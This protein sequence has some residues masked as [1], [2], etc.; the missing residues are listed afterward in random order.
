MITRKEVGS[1][2]KYFILASAFLLIVIFSAVKTTAVDP[3]WSVSSPVN[4][5]SGQEDQTQVYSYNLTANIS[6]PDPSMI[7][8]F[9]NSPS[10]DKPIISDVHGINKDV[11]FFHWI[12]LNGTTGILK[13][14]ATRDNETA[15]YNIS[16]NLDF[17][18]ES[19]GSRMFVFNITAINDRPY[20][21]S[22]ANQSFNR[23]SLFEYIVNVSDEESNTPYSMNITFLNCSVAAWSTRNCSGSYP[24]LTLFNSSQYSFS[25]NQ[26][27]ISFTPS[28]NDVG[29]YTINFTVIDSGNTTLPH[30]ASTSQIVLFEV[31]N[32][33]EIPYF[34]F[35]CNTSQSASAREDLQFPCYINATDID[36]LN[37]LT[38]SANYTWFNFSESNASSV[39]I[40]GQYNFSTLVKIN[41]TDLQVGNWSINITITDRGVPTASNSTILNL[42][43]A[44]INDSVSLQSIPDITAYTSQTYAVLVNA[45]DNDLLIP[46]K[47]VLNEALTFTTNNT[48]VTV[49]NQLYFSGT[50][51]SQVTLSFDPNNFTSGLNSI[52]VTVRDKDNNSISSDIFTINISDNSAPLWNA[53]ME[54]NFTLIEGTE[55]Y[56]NLSQNV[57]DTEAINFSLAVTSSYEFDMT[58]N[59]T[60]GVINFTPTD[61]DVGFHEV[62]ITATDGKTPST[63]GFNF[64]VNNTPDTPVFKEL[65]VQ[66]G[67]LVGGNINLTEDTPIGLLLQIEDDDLLI[68]QTNFYPESFTISSNITGPN[69]SLFQF[70]LQFPAPNNVYQFNSYFTPRKADIGVY[71]LTFNVTDAAGK[72]MTVYFNLTI[73]ETLHSPNITTSIANTNLSILNESFYIDVNATDV[74]DGADG[75]NSNLTFR[76]Q[77]LTTGGNFLTVN[78][79]TGVI[80]FTSNSSLGGKWQF[81]LFVNDTDGSEDSEY[82]NLTI[83]NYPVIS[84]PNSTYTFHLVENT[85]AV[86]NFSVNHTVQDNLNFTLLVNGVVQNS[87][88]GYGNNSAF[89][90]NYTPDF[91]METICSGAVNLTL[92]VSNPKLSNTTS[93]LVTINH[94]NSPLTFASNISAQSGGTPITLAL[95][96]YFSDVDAS[97]AC[98]NQTVGF[99]YTQ[100]ADS[101]SGGVISVSIVNWSGSGTS[102]SA[103]FSAETDGSANFSITAYEY[104][105]S[106][107]S[108]V[109]ASRVSNNF[110]VSLVV[111]DSTSTPQVSSGGGGGSRTRIVSLKILVPEPVS[112]KQKDKLI[113][114][115]SLENDGDLDLSRIY[116]DAVIAKDGAIRSDLVASFDQSYFESL[117]AGAK[118]NVTMV[119]DIDTSSVGLFE[120][121]INATVESP[122]YFDWAKFYIEIE[123]DKTVLE[124]IIFTEEFIIGNPQCAELVDLINDAKKLFDEGKELEA[125]AKAEEALSACN[126]AITQPPRPRIYERL[127]DK[128]IGFTAIASLLAFGL[129]FAYYTYR[130]VSLNRQLGISFRKNLITS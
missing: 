9:Y 40:S 27:N 115:L 108:Q 19:M 89:L 127:S 5:T 95:S 25:G 67:T 17:N 52:N 129:G 88:F 76:I 110:S 11:S 107:S 21:V 14:N 18:G 8:E 39:N 38:F 78:S 28:R 3:S 90:W 31:L 119:V 87:T 48:F 112:A 84:L 74:E 65:F 23:S 121:T 81:R 6:N 91:T 75:A 96:N 83:Y 98:A 10:G 102:P 109:L 99:N 49:S 104:N 113:I 62:T 71:N 42:F 34:T 51:R 85:T 118:E 126:K 94:T 36:E 114:P 86:L 12:S 101:A 33:N 43:F 22:L 55:F 117:K 125:A 103:T 57:T 123:E 73:N 53:T 1:K 111:A 80:N 20:F 26:L 29:N 4:T 72:S 56:L 124:K 69:S 59:Q 68:E 47:T 46:D 77:N 122:A 82:F 45:T 106:N 63:K 41:A 30:N 116:L 2:V 35:V 93:W 92:N 66:N 50:N 130:K 105:S 13:I 100:I 70:S 60:T 54:T 44:N 7:F 58:I 37:N 16:I 61:D 15:I 97:D 79:S 32:I 128:F 24:N 120:V 64:T